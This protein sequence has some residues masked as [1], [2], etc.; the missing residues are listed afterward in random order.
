MVEQLET[1][2]RTTSTVLETKSK[3]DNAVQA[4][5]S[6][7][8]GLIVARLETERTFRRLEAAQCI[9][10]PAAGL[11][12]SR[13]AA[14]DARA[15]LDQASLKLSGLRT[16]V[17]ELGS[18][19]VESYDLLATELP[20]YNATIISEFAEEWG[21]A[22]MAWN[23][24]L[25]RRHALET[26]LGQALD[27]VE[28]VPA[29]VT[30]SPDV[31]RPS[32]TLETLESNIKS[33]ANLKKIGE[34]QLKPG[35]YYD[36]SKIYKLVSDRWATR[37]VP[38]GSLV[39]DASFEPGRLSQI[40]ELGEARPILDRDQISGITIAAAKASEIDK[41]AAE[42]ELVNSARLHGGPDN[43][44]TRRPDLEAERNFKPSKADLDKASADI[45]AGIAAGVEAREVQ[46]VIDKSLNEAAEKDAARAAEHAEQNKLR[47][48][49]PAD[50]KPE[51][52]DAL[53]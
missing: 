25:G 23:L 43:S 26:L 39:C 46:R 19:L 51:W 36:P 6:E 21:C 50:P 48:K 14:A 52:P 32:E 9:G 8:Q 28:P 31:S 42:R 16:A 34:R 47:Q 10:E 35:T 11:E 20:R 27:L 7:L 12:K 17:G 18:S 2:L 1:V 38:K 41:A 40:I 3:L 44:S 22:L 13:K 37:G 4:G 49:P 15:A 33:I 53:H 30:L 24:A 45:A 29:T 5:V